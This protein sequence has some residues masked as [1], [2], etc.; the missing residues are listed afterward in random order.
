VFL[1][2][3]CLFVGGGPFR[4]LVR[5][6]RRYWPSWLVIGGVSLVYLAVYASLASSSLRRPRSVVEVLTFVRELV[7]ATLLP[8][9]IG[10][11]WRWL[12]AGDGT[13]VTQPTSVGQWLS[14][15]IFLLIVVVTVRLRPI[16]TRAW[17]LLLLYVVMV[18]ALLS[19]TRLNS[20]FSAAAGLVPRYV[21]EVVVVAAL[22]L[23]VALLGLDTSETSLTWPTGQ[24]DR[25]IL[26]AGLSLLLVA[27]VGS[28]AWSSTQFADDWAVKQGREYLR[29]AEADLAGAPA[30]TE[31][32]DLEVPEGVI[33]KLSWPYTKQSKFFR[34]A[35]LQPVFVTETENLS[36]FDPAGHIRSARIEGLKNQPGPISGCGYRVGG[37]RTVRIPLDGAKERWQWAVRIAYLSS[38]DTDAVL[39]YGDG[40]RWFKVH[41]GLGQIFFLIE[42]GGGA[43]E[44]T[45]TGTDA[46]AGLC[47]N[48]IAVGN[49]APDL[50]R[51]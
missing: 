22:A 48:E 25:T 3:A 20:D 21:S 24:R 23:G 33:T 28:A 49:P 34:P 42:G 11:P 26:A 16:A 6:V 19:A 10:G 51:G 30:G 2:T 35:K 37:G 50:Q 41:R 36:M 13:P 14:V 18:A 7:T 1:V 32:F 9:L 12:D 39:R 43:V 29:T 45:V 5:T 44:L 4:S 38:G 40:L 47:T 8:G 46:D 17:I 27:L 15:A 31:F